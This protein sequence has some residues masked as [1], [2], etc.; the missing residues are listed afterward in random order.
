M[1]NGLQVSATKMERLGA[2]VKVYDVLS[3]SGMVK[4]TIFRL[5]FGVKKESMSNLKENGSIL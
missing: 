2:W 3:F 4:A 1:K 5:S